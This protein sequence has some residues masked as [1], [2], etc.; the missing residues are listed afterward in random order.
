MFRFQ[1][2]HLLALSVCLTTTAFANDPARGTRDEA[3]ALAVAAA[4]HVAS[5][6]ATQAFKDFSSD[7]KWRPKDM[8]VFAQDMNANMLYHG[9][10]EKL[11]GKNFTEMRDSSGKEFNKEMIA[12]AKKGSGWVDY[13]WAHPATKKIEDKS[14]YIVKTA[15]PE[16]FV[17]VGI[18]R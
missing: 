5:V 12:T 7:P 1:R 8:F 13:Q 11:V 3:K 14:A 18:Y 6:G 9:A 15:K 16:G 10:N 2:R 4:A 17:A